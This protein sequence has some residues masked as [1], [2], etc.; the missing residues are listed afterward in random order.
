[1]YGVFV[2]CHLCLAVTKGFRS[3]QK[4]RHEGGECMRNCFD[5]AV[6][7]WLKPVLTKTARYC[8]AKQCFEGKK[9]RVL[10]KNCREK[11]TKKQSLQQLYNLFA[12][13]LLFKKKNVFDCLAALFSQIVPGLTVRSVVEW[14]LASPV[15]F[16]CGARFYK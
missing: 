11:K 13:E 5:F 10:S 12:N 3:H 6:P 15:Q 8:F 7:A 1:M 9:K 2:L 4:G 16:I 14:A